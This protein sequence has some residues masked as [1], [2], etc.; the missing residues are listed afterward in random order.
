MFLIGEHVRLKADLPG[1]SRVKG[2]LCRVNCPRDGKLIS[3]GNYFLSRNEYDVDFANGGSLTV[4]EDDLERDETPKI[5]EHKVEVSFDFKVTVDFDQEAQVF[6]S[7]CPDLDIHSQGDSEADALMGLA[8][9]MIAYLQEH[10]K[11]GSLNKVLSTKDLHPSKAI[12]TMN[13]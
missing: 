5:S 6:A 7:H 9:C 13:L 11:Q 10:K 1:T 4:S 2:E 8:D 3:K 12:A